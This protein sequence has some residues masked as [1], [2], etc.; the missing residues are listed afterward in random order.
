MLDIRDEEEEKDMPSFL[1]GMRSSY[2]D[3][4]SGDGGVD[5]EEEEKAIEDP[6]DRFAS[7]MNNDTVHLTFNDEEED[8]SLPLPPEEEVQ[9][10]DEE[11]DSHDDG[12]NTEDSE[13]EDYEDGNFYEAANY[14]PDAEGDEAEEDE[15][16][17]EYDD[18]DDRY[19]QMGNPNVKVVV[20]PER[21]KKSGTNSFSLIHF[22]LQSLKNLRNRFN[23]WVKGIKQRRLEKKEKRLESEKEALKDHL[24]EFRYKKW[25]IDDSG[26]FSKQAVKELRKH[27]KVI[28]KTFKKVKVLKRSVAKAKYEDS[29]AIKIPSKRETTN[30]I[31]DRVKESFYDEYTDEQVDEVIAKKNERKEMFGNLVKNSFI[32]Y[33]LNPGKIDKIISDILGDDYAHYPGSSH[34]DADEKLG[35]LAIERYLEN[36]EF[37]VD[38]YLGPDK[39]VSLKKNENTKAE[40]FDDEQDVDGLSEPEEGM[41]SAETRDGA[42]TLVHAMDS[43][44]QTAGST[45]ENTENNSERLESEYF[46]SPP[47]DDT[48]N[49]SDG[50]AQTAEEGIGDLASSGLPEGAGVITAEADD[51]D[52]VY[53]EGEDLTTGTVAGPETAPVA[54]PSAT[55]T[56]PA[57]DVA[58]TPAEVAVED[59][60]NVVYTE[61]EDLAAETVAGPTEAVPVAEPSAT[62]T[63]PASDV[64]E[65]PAEVAVEDNEEG[66]ATEAVAAP[67]AVPV[68]APEAVPVAEPSAAETIPVSDV[69]ETP[70][71]VAVEDNTNAVYTEGEDLAAEAVAAPEAVPVAEPSAAE[72]IPASDVAETPA[73]VAVENDTNAVYTE[74]EDLAAETVAAPEAVPVAEPS[75]AETIPASDV[76]ETPAEVAVEDN[77]NAVYTEGEGL[78]AE[79]VAAPEAVPVTEASVVE[80]PTEESAPV[81]EVEAQQEN[82]GSTDIISDFGTNQV[83]PSGHYSTLDLSGMVQTDAG[84]VHADV[85]HKDSDVAEE[86][87]TIRTYNYAEAKEKY[88]YKPMTAEEIKAAGKVI[89]IE[90]SYTGSD[91][92]VRDDVVVAPQRDVYEKVADIDLSAVDID[93]MRKHL[94]DLVDEELQCSKVLKHARE[95]QAIAEAELATANQKLEQSRGIYA[96]RVALSYRAVKKKEAEIKQ[97]KALADEVNKQIHRINEDISGINHKKAIYDSDTLELENMCAGAGLDIVNTGGRMK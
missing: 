18:D 13:Y 80:T 48:S 32:I 10:E 9:E 51:E 86:K 3:S 30:S 88:N 54:E 94:A 82:V 61:G 38:A 24:E 2:S 8:D 81:E 44:K 95:K 92:A 23:N 22:S 84:V 85:T 65:T 73:E 1:R 41:S 46:T 14:E 59:D 96:E 79:T 76:A 39:W 35:T 26:N 55:E 77:T 90:D 52:I 72:T 16:Y 71:E 5:S 91:K 12:D 70:A 15:E 21:V 68:A 28:A 66:L 37:G 49:I 34:E 75:A 67:E 83:V 40:E 64:A 17:D 43:G 25:N 63:I 78:A 87:S 93:S 42:K 31:I 57:P 4:D 62:E 33:R 69:A 60:T 97:K 29:K 45:G 6:D 56:I 50:S 20:P 27:A 11:A 74:G 47:A 36:G 19:T 7:A 58:E 89:G 53:T